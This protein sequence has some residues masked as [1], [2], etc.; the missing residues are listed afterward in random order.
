[1]AFAFSC[2]AWQLMI[3][4]GEIHPVNYSLYQ[5]VAFIFIVCTMHIQNE[6]INE[7][8]ILKTRSYLNNITKKTQIV[9][10]SDTTDLTPSV[11]S[12]K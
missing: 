1:V 8:F 12:K 3:K 10:V 4:L 11:A 5:N 6:S 2:D 7:P 9:V